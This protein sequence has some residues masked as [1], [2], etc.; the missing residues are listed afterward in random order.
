MSPWMRWLP[1]AVVVWLVRLRVTDRDG[2]GRVSRI[3]TE[4]FPGETLDW[5]RRGYR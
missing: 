5:K 1:W 3:I 4:V 2:R